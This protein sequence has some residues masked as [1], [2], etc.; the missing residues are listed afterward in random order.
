MNS[1]K[2]EKWAQKYSKLL[3]LI[4]FMKDGIIANFIVIL[5]FTL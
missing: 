4:Y 2:D 3:C 5:K 1:V